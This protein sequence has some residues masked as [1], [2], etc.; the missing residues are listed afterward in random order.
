MK[1]ILILFALLSISI[2]AQN[3]AKTL[4]TADSV[5][6]VYG[7]SEWIEISVYDSGN[8]D[9]VYVQQPISDGS[10][11]YYAAIGKIMD[12]STGENVTGLYGNAD[13]KIYVLWFPY[14]RAIRFYLSDYASGSV[15]IKVT[16]KP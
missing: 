3:V 8:A 15:F 14:P 9:T 6:W 12:L 16:G 5:L 13:Q 2:F 4:T 1:K 11:T 7:Q 10:N